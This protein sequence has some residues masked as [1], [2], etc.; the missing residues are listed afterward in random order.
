MNDLMK[1]IQLQALDLP[2]FREVRGKEWISYGGDNMYPQKLIE[3]QH[4]S[5]IHNTAIRS[6]LDAVIGEGVEGVG[7]DYVNA[8]NEN[9]NDIYKKIAFD[10]LMFGGY[11]LNIIWNRAGDRIA[12][13]YHL[14]FSKVR[15]GK[16]NEEDKVE[17]YYYSSNWNNT[18][19]YKPNSYPSFSTT[20][21]KGDYAS[22]IFYFY[23]YSPGC[24]IYPLPD[25]IGAINDIELDARVSRFH[26]A[27]I[28]NGM[29]PGLM[30]NFPNGEATPEERRRLYNDL[31][32]SFAG[33]ENAGRVFLTFSEGSE[34][35]PSVQT[36]DSAN[37]DYYVVLETRISS[38]I[39]TAHRITSP[40]LVGIRD[41]GTGL[42]N[43]ANELEVAYTHFMSTVIEPIQE[44]LNKSFE[45]VLRSF[46][47]NVRVKV[48]P[49]TLD[50]NTNIE[51][52]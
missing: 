46:G 31:N 23:E 9:I 32:A 17:E 12:E 37:D 11:A 18:R 6:K 27:N 20:K 26:N 21:T 30:I 2:E 36:I 44:D 5:A 22:Q 7:L 47:L 51:G 43:N 15:S 42:G 50:F 10:F 1:I 33:E 25:Y 41:T 40:L 38:R 24:D 16:M 39:L 45:R 14:D 28:S 34:L 52:K 49:S 8:N 4:T 29:S 3:L 13:I 35:A 48:I 19:K